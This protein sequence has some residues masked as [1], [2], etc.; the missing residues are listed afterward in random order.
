[1][2]LAEIYLR[3]QVI[4]VKRLLCVS[5]WIFLNLVTSFFIQYRSTWSKSTFNA[6]KKNDKSFESDFVQNKVDCSLMVVQYVVRKI[7]LVWKF[8]TPLWQNWSGYDRYHFLHIHRA[9]KKCQ[10]KRRFRRRHSQSWSKWK[11]MLE[12]T[13]HSKRDEMLGRL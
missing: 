2:L 7:E 4:H 5:K 6:F 3:P 10:T 1:M 9:A 13:A 12:N 11:K 8:F